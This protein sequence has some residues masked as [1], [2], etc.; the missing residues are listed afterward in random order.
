ME[1]GQDHHLEAFQTVPA[2]HLQGTCRWAYMG[3]T[4]TT[5]LFHEVLLSFSKN[6]YSQK[7]RELPGLYMSGT[8]RL[9][10]ALTLPLK[11]YIGLNP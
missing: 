7:P 1:F 5:L 8:H 3:K 11:L 4:Q 6:S 2:T 10:L 9:T